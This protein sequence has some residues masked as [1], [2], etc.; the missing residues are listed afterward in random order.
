V[1]ARQWAINSGGAGGI[2]A[3][4]AEA[5]E[6]GWSRVEGQTALAPGVS[7][8]GL[9]NHPGLDTLVGIGSGG[10]QLKEDYRRPS[11]FLAIARRRRLLVATARPDLGELPSAGSG[12]ELV[13]DSRA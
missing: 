9:A 12:S 7:P 13:E 5:V 6:G 2:S 1:W 8:A 3:S 11:F 4:G 10:V